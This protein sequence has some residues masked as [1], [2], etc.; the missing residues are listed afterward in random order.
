MKPIRSLAL[1]L[2][3]FLSC[4]SS[5]ASAD[6]GLEIDSPTE[7]NVVYTIEPDDIAQ[8]EVHKIINKL[9]CSAG[10]K[11]GSRNDA[12]LFVRVEKHA[13]A[14]LLY[15]DFNR[16]LSYTANG[17]QRSTKGFVW[18]RYANNIDSQDELLEDLVFFAEEFFADYQ[19]ANNLK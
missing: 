15:L 18:G 12:Q 17:K 2:A 9:A 19:Q 11:L 14:Y 5:F 7:I 4:V 8:H 6:T 16:L 10:I 3:A 13:G 1:L